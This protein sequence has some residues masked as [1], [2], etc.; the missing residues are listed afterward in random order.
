[1]FRYALELANKFN[2]TLICFHAFGRPEGFSLGDE[3]GKRQKVLQKLKTFASDNTPDALSNVRLEFSAVLDY[4]ADAILG[5]A[6][7]EKVDLIILGMT[8]KSTESSR[9]LG[10]NA[11]KV[12][13]S[14]ECPVLAIPSTVTYDAVNKIVFTTDFEFEDLALLNFLEKG[15]DSEVHII[16]VVDKVRDREKAAARM[17]SLEEAYR[18]HPGMFF[19]II[20]G[21]D[22]E[23]EIERYVEA[24]KADLL[25]M[26]AHKQSVIQLLLT[27]STARNIAKKT[28]TPLLVFKQDG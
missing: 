4:P 25:A 20:E 17:K 26:T 7:K 12:I 13:G 22:V 27:G 6:E 16:H 14:A 2:A 21:K 18:K 1:M 11:L 5:I 9:F 19:E 24:N 10:S 15:F 23:A 28:K 3:E 8:G